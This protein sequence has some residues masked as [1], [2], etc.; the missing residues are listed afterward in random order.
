MNRQRALGALAA[1][2]FLGAKAA[3]PRNA[4]DEAIAEAICGDTD[5]IE[6]VLGAWEQWQRDRAKGG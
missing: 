5:D 3:D 1:A 4:A 2:S 6:A